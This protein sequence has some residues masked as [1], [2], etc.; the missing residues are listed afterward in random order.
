MATGL[1][2][3]EERAVYI[4]CAVGRTSEGGANV[5]CV[6]CE[7]T[8]AKL[9]LAGNPRENMPRLGELRR[10]LCARCG[11]LLPTED[12]SE[13]MLAK[14]TQLSKFGLGADDRPLL[15]G[16]PRDDA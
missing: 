3:V 12:P 16:Q 9:A 6:T 4:T 7:S 1:K 8:L 15:T 10:L 2:L 14:L 13:V 11:A 5:L